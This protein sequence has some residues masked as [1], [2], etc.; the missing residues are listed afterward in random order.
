M[1][2]SANL[3]ALALKGLLGGACKAAGLQPGEAA[4]EGVVGFLTRHFTDH[5]QR[6]GEAL[7][8]TNDRAWRAL[9]VALAGESLWDRC[10]LLLASAEDKSFREQVRPF[11]DACPLAE[12][13]GKAAYRQSCLDE[14]RTA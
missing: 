2:I 3:C 11:L 5:S 4:V 6:L 10:K 14:L 1:R 7:R 8:L 9:E 13:Q 12:M